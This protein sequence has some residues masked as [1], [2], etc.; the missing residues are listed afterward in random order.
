MK[1]TLNYL[2]KM[3][4]ISKLIFICALLVGFSAIELATPEATDVLSMDTS[5]GLITNE[6]TFLD[7][8]W[9]MVAGF[10]VFFMQAGFALVET[11]FT[12]AKNVAN[13][14]MKNMM[15]LNTEQE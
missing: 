9:I 5:A 7:L 3:C 1:E 6:K 11:G 8:L 15:D 12:R 2:N 14:M 4:K 13:I 10:L